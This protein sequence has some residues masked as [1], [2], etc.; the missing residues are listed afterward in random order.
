MPRI[1]YFFYNALLLPL[2]WFY[3][4]V[5][6]FFNDKVKAGFDGRKK[7]FEHLEMSG[8]VLNNGNKNII[9]HSSSFGEYQQAL[10]LIEELHKRNYNVIV[11][12]FSPSGF[13][14]A[15]LPFERMV[16]TYLP[17]DTVSNVNRFFQLIHPVCIFFVRYDLWYNLLFLAK[18]KNIKTYIMNARYDENDKL[19]NVP[20]FRDFKKSL[21]NMMDKMYVIDQDDEMNFKTEFPRKKEYI[22]RVGDSKY[23][24]VYEASKN[25][26][27]I[28]VLDEKIIKGKKIFVIGSSWKDDEEIILPVINKVSLYD[29]D[30]LTVLVPHEPKES[31]IKIIEKNI[32]SDY[33]NLSYIR[34]SDIEKYN[35]ENLI[36]IDCIGKLISLYSIAYASYVGGGFN[37]GLHNVL[38]PAI[39]NI[40]VFFSNE[41]KHS[42][43]DEILIDAG[44]G[45]V[46]RNSKRF[47]RDF[48]EIIKDRHLRNIIGERCKLVFEES[49]GTAEKII[50]DLKL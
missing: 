32:S 48:R 10:P 2:L 16:K 37:T 47:Y 21:Y 17:L 28:K 14:N 36:I 8:A 40:P 3:F 39:F 42:D 30:L 12:F 44:C 19:W 49:L 18:K 34:L 5:Y 6:S 11:S 41:V 46:V 50:S 1:W 20:A 24:R 15:Q 33:K 43:E 22:V 4:R 13:N 35:G 31:K 25:A 26:G 23:E 7:I 45:L 27:K 9:V 38:E 29:K